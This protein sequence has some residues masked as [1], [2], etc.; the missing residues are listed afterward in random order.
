MDLGLK[1]PILL[2]DAAPTCPYCEAMGWQFSS[3][4]EAKW[5]AFLDISESENIREFVFS[6][7]SLFHDSWDGF[8]QVA[9]SRGFKIS[10]WNCGHESHSQLTVEEVKTKIN[11][12]SF[13][14]LVG[15][16]TELYSLRTKW[17]I[18]SSPLHLCFHEKTKVST[19]KLF[20]RELKQDLY[21]VWAVFPVYNSARSIGITGQSLHTLFYK[22]RGRRLGQG[23]EPVPGL[24]MM[25]V[26]KE[27]QVDM[28]P[29]DIQ[30]VTGNQKPKFSFVIPAFG[31]EI[32][33][34]TVLNRLLNLK[35]KNYEI[36]LVDDGNALPLDALFQ[37][38]VTEGMQGTYLRLDRDEKHLTHTFRAGRARNLGAKYAR[39]E[40]L[41]FL[42]SDILVS[43]DYLMQVESGLKQFDFVQAV[44]LDLRKDQDISDASPLNC[45]PLNAYWERFQKSARINWNSIKHPWKY[46]CT[47][48]L[49]L[50]RS[51]FVELGGFSSLFNSYGY[52]DTDF[53]FRGYRAR[54]TFGLIKDP[55][56]HLQREQEFTKYKKTHRVRFNSLSRSGDFFMRNHWDQESFAHMHYL[57]DSKRSRW[58]TF[59][60]LGK[61][62]VNKLQRQSGSL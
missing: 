39:G 35:N 28:T 7:P 55:V 54:K 24:E 21:P 8:S 22:T 38:F 25:D 12:A 50:K 4:D 40:I 26:R 45:L 14:P 57:F 5:S 31:D 20:E 41:C 62:L 58:T 15:K 56:L 33:I 6:L 60:A 46:I 11:G 1:R 44:R 19:L 30:L 59:Q 17:K 34:K 2:Q 18:E 36:V 32:E 52:E 42:D 9:R 43:S 10:V 13:Y 27:S 16:A 23:L 3:G 51:L 53:G 47:H 37:S 61:D 49:S 29:V 48:S